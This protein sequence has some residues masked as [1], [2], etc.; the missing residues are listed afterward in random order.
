MCYDIKSTLE[1]HLRRAE[2]LDDKQSY[3]EALERLWSYL[4]DIEREQY[5]VSGFSHP[6][7]VIQFGEG[8]DDL[9][10]SSEQIGCDL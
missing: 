4:S 2:L 7:V 6:N 1:A 10:I 5:H 8:V 3:Q 9:A